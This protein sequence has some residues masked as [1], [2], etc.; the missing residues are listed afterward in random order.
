MQQRCPSRAQC[1]EHVADPM[2]CFFAYRETLMIHSEVFLVG[3]CG[4]LLTEET[5]RLLISKE[6][7]ILWKC[8]PQ[9]YAQFL[10]GRNSF[11]IDPSTNRTMLNRDRFQ[12][13]ITD[14]TAVWGQMPYR[15][16]CNGGQREGIKTSQAISLVCSASL[17]A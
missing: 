14:L 1:Q 15:F 11:L 12:E 9:V 3:F 5:F 4:I 7:Y 16:L 17:P 2:R 13:A 8:S 6:E 10:V